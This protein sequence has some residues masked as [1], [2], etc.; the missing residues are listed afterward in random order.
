MAYELDQ[1]I[2]DCRSILQRDPGPKG[3]ENVR[4]HLEKLLANKD[5]VAKTCGDDAP[6]GLKVLYEDKE[7][8]FQVLAH[9][10]DKAR[11]SPPHDH[12]ASWAIYG[13]ATK[14]TDMIEWARVSGDDRHAELKE[15]KRYRLNPGQAGIYADGAIHSID[16]PERARFIRVTGTNLDRIDRVRFDLKTGEVHR[17]TPQQAT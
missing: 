5:F 7:L 3:R 12:G 4:Q 16:S 15:V 10:N 17:M 1:F 14:H 9:V 13:Q 11:K 6:L 2:S 8:G